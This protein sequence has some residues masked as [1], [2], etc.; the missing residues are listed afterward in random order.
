MKLFILVFLLGSPSLA[1]E[2]KPGSVALTFDDG[3]DPKHTLQILK[4]LKEQN[5]KAT[6]FMLGIKARQYPELVKAVKADGHVI[7]NHSY[8]HANLAHLNA[9]KLKYE[10]SETNEILK[11]I[12]G[13]E[14][15]CLRPPYG[16][17]SKEV[18]AV[19][20]QAGLTVVTWDLNSFDYTNETPAKEE[21]WVLEKAKSGGVILMHDALRGGAHTVVALPNIIAGYK[22]RG[23]RFDTICN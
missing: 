10:I 17:S 19:S 18:R 6:F 15:K 8:N 23:V 1:A 13:Q 21:Q 12:T 5:V 7:A 16:A 20:A 2:L 14:P 22:K 9:N 11:Q 3:P 4:I